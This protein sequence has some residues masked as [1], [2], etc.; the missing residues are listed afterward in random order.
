MHKLFITRI[1]GHLYVWKSFTHFIIIYATV[2]STH[3]TSPNVA[4]T[5]CIHSSVENEFTHVSA[6]WLFCELE[7]PGHHTGFHTKFRWLITIC[8]GIRMYLIRL[9]I[10]HCTAYKP[11][12]VR[13]ILSSIT[14]GFVFLARSE[15][16]KKQLNHDVFCLNKALD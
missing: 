11:T 16:N 15:N 12:L 4:V 7:L 3:S 6:R 1:F 2:P 9:R 13:L 8:I 14:R 10:W 5:Q